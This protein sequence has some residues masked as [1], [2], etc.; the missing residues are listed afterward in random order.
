LMQ[1]LNK[2]S[3]TSGLGTGGFYKDYASAQAAYGPGVDLQFQNPVG[4]GAPGG[5]YVTPST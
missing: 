2:P 1:A 4:P 3:M 5:F